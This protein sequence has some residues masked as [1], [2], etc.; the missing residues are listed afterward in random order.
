[1]KGKQGLGKRKVKKG[2]KYEEEERLEGKISKL[3]LKGMKKGRLRK[4][5]GL[6]PKLVI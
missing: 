6:C 4:T 3:E 5:T 1:M 2:W